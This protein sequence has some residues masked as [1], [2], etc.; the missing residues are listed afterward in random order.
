M[1]QDSFTNDVVPIQNPPAPVHIPKIQKKATT[2]TVKK[3]IVEPAKQVHTK[4][5]NPT[6]PELVMEV[7]AIE[8]LLSEEEHEQSC[9]EGKFVDGDPDLFGS[10]L[11]LTD[12]CLYKIVR[13]ARN[14]PDFTTVSVSAH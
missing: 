10:L 2:E 4:Q 14:L 1:S 3:T 9:C 12:H 11:H 13:W 6:I 7:M 5:V 8:S